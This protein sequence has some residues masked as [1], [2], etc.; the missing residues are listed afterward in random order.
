MNNYG[1]STTYGRR[2][3]PKQST[4]QTVAQELHTVALLQQSNS[5]ACVTHETTPT[6]RRIFLVLPPQPLYWHV[7]GNNKHTRVQYYKIHTPEYIVL[8]QTQFKACLLQQNEVNSLGQQRVASRVDREPTV[9][10]CSSTSRMVTIV[11]QIV[12]ARASCHPN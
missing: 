4:T 10:S 1:R 8:R 2:F 9:R 7:L 12:S 5:S 6:Y 11:L 3:S